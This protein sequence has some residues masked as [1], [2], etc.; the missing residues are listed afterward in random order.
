MPNVRSMGVS[1]AE[2]VMAEA[3]FQ[4]RV[5]AAPVNYLGLGFVVYTN[6]RARSAA[7]KGSTITLFV[8]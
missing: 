3:G 4:T 1:A 8:V 6:P 5:Q 2:R 7:P